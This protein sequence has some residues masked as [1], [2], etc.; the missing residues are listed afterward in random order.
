MS[1]LTATREKGVTLME[2]LVTAVIAGVL[3]AISLPNMIVLYNKS[4]VQ[5]GLDMVKGSFQDAQLQAG[6]V[7]RNCDI[8]L[9]K[10]STSNTYYDLIVARGN[11]TT[12]TNYCFVA[13][14]S[15][16]QTETVGGTTQPLQQIQLPGGVNQT[17]T[18]GGTTQP[19]Q[20]IQLP[21]GVRM[22]TNITDRNGGSPAT[23]GLPPTLTFS[24]KGHI[25][26]LASRAPRNQLP[27]IVIFPVDESTESP[28]ENNPRQPRKCVMVGSLLGILR[29]GYYSTTA[30]LSSPVTNANCTPGIDAR[31]N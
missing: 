12:G 27:T 29:T 21:R 11:A 15:Q 30:S 13:M 1:L 19:L 20:Q 26:D 9:R 5:T 8:E 28:Y 25:P 23:T 4:K 2:V 31:Q 7:G 3:A 10:S 14:A 24:F 22:A 16:Y 6:R 18:V 17:E